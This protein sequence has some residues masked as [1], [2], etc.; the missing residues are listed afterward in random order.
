LFIYILTILTAASSTETVASG[1][2]ARSQFPQNFLR[3]MEMECPADN[4]DK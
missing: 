2:G 3:A 1:K 4:G